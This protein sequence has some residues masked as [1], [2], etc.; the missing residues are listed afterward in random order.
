M[1]VTA[2]TWRMAFVEEPARLIAAQP[3]QVGISL[4]S[5][6]LTAVYFAGPL[7]GVPWLPSWVVYIVTGAAA[8]GVEYAFLK[9][10]ADRAYVEAHGGTGIWGDVLIYT[11]GALLVVGGTTVLLTYAYRLPALLHPSDTLAA[12]LAL[13]HVAPLALIGVCSAQLHAAA[14]RV[15]IMVRHQAAQTFEAQ[16]QAIDLEVY[17]G[18]QKA[19]ARVRVRAAQAHSPAQTSNPHSPHAAAQS[20]VRPMTRDDLCAAVRVAHADN[21]EFSRADMARRSG[22]SEAMV[23]KVLRAI[24]EETS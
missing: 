24:Q 14:E 21:P 18:E 3:A 5:M 17:E 4:L 22:W 6:L 7:L 11:T 1:S 15:A 16:R 23:R 12:V 8:L 9:G 19:L 2:R 13:A 10:V 20:A